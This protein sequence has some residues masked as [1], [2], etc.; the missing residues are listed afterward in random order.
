MNDT[1]E[2]NVF[3]W[4]LAVL[5]MFK[6]NR[7]LEPYSTTQVR[8]ILE[9]A[10]APDALSRLQKLRSDYNPAPP[11]GKS[12]EHASGFLKS[13]RE[14]NSAFVQ[15]LIEVIR[16]NDRESIQQLSQYILWNIKILEN[17][18]I[19]NDLTDFIGR[20]EL[21]LQC[22]DIDGEGIV[23]KIKEIAVSGQGPRKTYKKG[24]GN[25]SR[26]SRR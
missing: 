3:A 7:G 1:A 20:L 17:D 12:P 11:Q 22:E 16:D 4:E 24:S 10:A 15:R 26:G 9:A 14:K 18:R 13:K 5:A 23:D 25:H 21:L 19:E 2:I 6:V 8:K